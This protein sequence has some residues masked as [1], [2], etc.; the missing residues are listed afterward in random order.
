MVISYLASTGGATRG[1]WGPNQKYR[2]YPS[3][4]G[5]VKSKLCQQKNRARGEAEYPKH[6][7]RAV[8]DGVTRQQDFETEALVV[9]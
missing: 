9:T 6:G 2:W 1:C 5:R 8:P 7:Q 4:L 3:L